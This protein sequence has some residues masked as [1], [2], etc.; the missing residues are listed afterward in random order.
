MLEYPVG[1]SYLEAL[2]E[3]PP[4]PWGWFTQE[5]LDLYTDAYRQSGFR[6]V[7]NHYT[8]FGLPMSS[9]TAEQR[10][11]MPADPKRK[12]AEPTCFICG[13]K[14]MDLVDV[15]LFGALPLETMRQ[16]LTDLRE[17]LVVREAGHL[18]HMEKPNEVNDCI[19]RFLDSL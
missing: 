10:P 15:S 2:P 8:S 5:D 16:R 17:V 4:L 13:D 19:V 14:D 12:I 18:I 7:V 3:T 11:K 6:G 9:L 1:T